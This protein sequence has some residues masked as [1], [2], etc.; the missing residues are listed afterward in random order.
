MDTTNRLTHYRDIIEKILM[1]YT[2]IPYAYGHIDIRPSFD[3]TRD[4]Y[5]VVNVGW[6]GERRVHGCLIHVEINNGKVWIE[7][8]G[9]EDG[10][11]NAL[12]AA[13]IP[14]EHIVLGF[15]PAEMRP[16]TEFA[17]A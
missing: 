16:Y 5:L 7:R 14:K 13:G 4:Q 10:I 11:A 15:R 3:R 9:T 17:V 2:T 1:T 12:V 6:D 8:D